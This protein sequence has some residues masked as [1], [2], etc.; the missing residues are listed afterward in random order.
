MNHVKALPERLLFGFQV[1][2]YGQAYADHIH[3]H[4]AVE[5]CIADHVVN[6]FQFKFFPVP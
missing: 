2:A 6:R 5:N 3:G 4:G 1:E